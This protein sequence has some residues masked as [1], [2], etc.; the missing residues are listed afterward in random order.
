MEIIGLNNKTIFWSSEMVE[1]KNQN[2]AYREVSSLI[3]EVSKWDIDKSDKLSGLIETKYFGEMTLAYTEFNNQI[4]S[5]DAKQIIRSSMDSYLVQLVIA[6]D[7][8][9][10]FN[11]KDIRFGPGDVLI[12]DLTQTMTAQVTS[13]AR[14]AVVV[15]RTEFHRFIIE[16]NLHGTVLPATDPTTR[17]IAHYLIGLQ[18]VCSEMSLKAVLSAQEALLLILSGTLNSQH[19][20]EL[21]L[22]VPIKRGIVDFIDKHIS[23]PYLNP[24]MILSHFRVSRSH[25]YRAFEADG[26][27][28]KLIRRKRL[29]L[30]FRLLSNNKV[31]KT[32]I[33]EVVFQCGMT[34]VTNFAKIFK[35]RF[36][37]TPGEARNHPLLFKKTEH[38]SSLIRKVLSDT[39]NTINP[40]SQQNE[41][42][43]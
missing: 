18:K 12:T 36:G 21:P 10:N 1:E 22:N 32:P 38:H 13:G 17:L 34:N 37:I 11:G 24:E 42:N 35:E 16:R 26:G 25:L 9:G 20:N 4:Y 8:K 39:I 27:I 40:E 15:P 7:A 33:K 29:D 43:R 30:A 23:N 14:I 3:Y 19:Y 6:G 31:S 2:D 5:R 41:F 28:A